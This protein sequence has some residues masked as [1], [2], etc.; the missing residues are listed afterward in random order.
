M[1][2]SVLSPAV[3]RRW[4]WF[5]W[6]LL[7]LSAIGIAAY[8]VPPYLTG[9]SAVPIDR[10]IVGYYASL[11]V[12]ALPAGLTLVIGPWQFVPKL[13]ARFPRLHRVLGRVY[14]I[15]VVAASMAAAYAAAVTESGFALQVAFYILIVAWLYTAVQAYRTIRRRE[16]ALHRIWMV[17]NYALT[18]AAVTLRVYL[19]VSMQVFPSVPFPELYTASAWAG[20]LGN[21]VVAE[22]FIVQRT[23]RPLARRRAAVAETPQPVG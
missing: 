12:H 15:S 20:V 5:L 22:Y 3:R 16:I 1:S 9:G 8:F 23:L 18:F 11:V 7:A 17:R 6:G 2:A 10:A 19:L 13:R 4:W 21:V 14:L